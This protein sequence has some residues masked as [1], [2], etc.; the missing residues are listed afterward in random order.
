[1]HLRNPNPPP[2]LEQFSQ[3]LVSRFGI[4]SCLQHKDFRVE[5]GRDEALSWGKVFYLEKTPE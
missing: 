2:N 1:M 4:G 5:E 3:M